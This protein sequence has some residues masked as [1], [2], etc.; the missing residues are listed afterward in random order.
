ME[1]AE[2]TPL[3]ENE[4]LK[5]NLCLSYRLCVWLVLAVGCTLSLMCLSSQ[6]AVFTCQFLQSRTSG[7]GSHYNNTASN[8]E[9]VTNNNETQ[10]QNSS[11]EWALAVL[12]FAYSVVQLPVAVFASRVGALRVSLVSTVICLVT[13]LLSI[14]MLEWGLVPSV[15]ICL[16]KG[17]SAVKAC[18]GEGALV[19]LMASL[20]SVW[21]G[22]VETTRVSAVL[23]GGSNIAD[24]LA[25][26]GTAA[27]CN[28]GLGWMKVYYLQGAMGLVF[29]LL[30]AH[31]VDERPGKRRC[32]SRNEQR[33]LASFM[34]KKGYVEKKTATPYRS[35]LTSVHVW[36]IVVAQLGFQ[37]LD[38]LRVSSLPVFLGVIHK[39]DTQKAEL[40]TAIAF[41]LSIPMG[42]AIATVADG[43]V[44]REVASRSRVRK[45]CDFLTAIYVISS[46]AVN[47]MD[48][49]WMANYYDLAPVHTGFLTSFG[50]LVTSWSWSVTAIVVPRLTPNDS[51]EEWR[52][53][54][55]M[56]AGLCGACSLFYMLFASGEQQTWATSPLDRCEE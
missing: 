38:C 1:S 24:S 43:L 13:I 16:V 41:L 15:M 40:L 5:V 14:P 4:N 56:G 54:M 37:W 3:T 39:V 44:E 17:A 23:E 50:E 18:T 22:P 46:A 29:F 8:A 21:S 26:L 33:L 30:L 25:F 7:T 48:G 27:F 6:A 53:V 12:Y 51:V 19:P 32:I 52:Y 45:T 11:Q 20:A 31:C 9:M 36:A 42:L 34:T 49:A 10:Q 28:A 35:I 55:Y 2:T 47:L